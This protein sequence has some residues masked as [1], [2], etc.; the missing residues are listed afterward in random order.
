MKPKTPGEE[1]LKK[2]L[3]APFKKIVENAGKDY[4]EIV[5]N[6]EENIG[7][8]AKKG[9]F[10]NMKEKGIIDPAKVERCAV[11]NAVSNVAQFITGFCSITDLQEQHDR[12]N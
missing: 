11:E 6:I 3:T 2:A 12:R 5:S 9:E 7:F 10:V 8:D 4:A 1:I